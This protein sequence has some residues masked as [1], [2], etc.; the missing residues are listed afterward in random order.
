MECWEY[1]DTA[2]PASQPALRSW[3]FKATLQHSHSRL[4]DFHKSSPFFLTHRTVLCHWGL[5]EKAKH[6][7]LLSVTAVIVWNQGSTTVCSKG[8]DV[9]HW[10]GWDSHTSNP[11]KCWGSLLLTS[12]AKCFLKPSNVKQDFEGLLELWECLLPHPSSGYRWIIYDFPERPV[13]SAWTQLCC[14]VYTRYSSTPF[15]GMSI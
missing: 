12:L 2:E 15:W 10:T 9:L 13:Q 1:R 5:E 11:L 4:Q 14:I 8:V 7:F 3:L 6:S